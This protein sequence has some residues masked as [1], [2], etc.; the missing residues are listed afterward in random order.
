[1]PLINKDGKKIKL[2]PGKYSG[3]KINK[4]LKHGVTDEESD[5]KRRVNKRRK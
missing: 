3:E 2:K 5:L 4:I 1:M